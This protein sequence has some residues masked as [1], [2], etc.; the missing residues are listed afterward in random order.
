[1]W[2]IIYFRETLIKL[3]DY[4]NNLCFFLLLLYIYKSQKCVEGGIYFIG[5]KQFEKVIKNRKMLARQEE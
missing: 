2:K 1:M 5:K 4:I 3:N